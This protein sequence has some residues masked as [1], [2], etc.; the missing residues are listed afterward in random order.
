MN[1]LGAGKTHDFEEELKL[2]YAL[3]LTDAETN[4][5]SRDAFTITYKK[6][7]RTDKAWSGSVSKNNAPSLL[8]C[9]ID[10]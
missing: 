8:S 6:P 4:M 3:E 7:G 1:I 9:G 5:I 2:I 10:M